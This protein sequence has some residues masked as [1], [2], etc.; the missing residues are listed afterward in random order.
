MLNSNSI[1]LFSSEVKYKVNVAVSDRPRGH[2][3]S[4][5]PSCPL[6]AGMGLPHWLPWCPGPHTCPLWGACMP[7]AQ[8]GLRE[9]PRLCA[10]G[11]CL[12]VSEHS[13]GLGPGS[14]RLEEGLGHI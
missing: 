6:T 4:R 9:G 11:I 13:L 3:G 5:G 12:E 1:L 8:E 14:P 7:F 2:P 10:D